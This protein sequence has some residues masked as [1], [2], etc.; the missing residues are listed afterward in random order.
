MP[1][2]SFICEDCKKEFTQFLHFAE[3]EKREVKCPECG[4]SNVR[5]KVEPFFAVT[6]K[7]S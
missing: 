1:Q 2:Y 6:S 3:F 5:H 7:K 4:S